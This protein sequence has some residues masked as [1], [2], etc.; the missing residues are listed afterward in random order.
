MFRVVIFPTEGEVAVVSHKWWVPRDDELGDG[1]VLWPPAKSTAGLN[2]LL[3]QHVVP[4]K[5][6]WS[7]HDG[8]C[9]YKTGK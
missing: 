9:I 8:R 6:K 7:L 3:V 1:Y 5:E 2:R 4:E